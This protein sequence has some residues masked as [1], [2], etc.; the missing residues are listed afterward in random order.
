MQALHSFINHGNEE[1][2]KKI[3][4]LSQTISKVS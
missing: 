1:A 4:A 3:L 2:G